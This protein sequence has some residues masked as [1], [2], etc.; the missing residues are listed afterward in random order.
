MKS[1][2]V[3]IF[4]TDTVMMLAGSVLCAVAINGFLRPHELISGGMAGT[5]LVIYYAWPKIPFPLMY[6]L[7]N[8]PVFMLGYFVVGRRFIWFSVW[9]TLIS[10]AMFHFVNPS[11]HIPNDRLMCA[12]VAGALNGTGVALILRTNGTSS[13]TEI[14]SIMVNKF[15]SIS[16][17][18]TNIIIN[19][20]LM[21]TAS[22]FLSLDKILYSFA[23]V[24]MNSIVM[25]AVFKGLARRKAVMIISKRWN[26]ILDELNRVRHIGVTILNAKGGYTGIDEPILYSIAKNSQVSNIRAV[27]LRIDPTAFVAI[28]ETTDIISDAIGNQPPWMYKV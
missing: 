23:F 25:N 12:L 13:G 2:N 8:I 19:A 10:S 14:I 15:Y 24:T 28:M 21:L 22:F 26:E 6:L 1:H 11:L 18:T 7:V 20:V 27:T 16:I 17:G 4:M 9:G 5:S 3:K